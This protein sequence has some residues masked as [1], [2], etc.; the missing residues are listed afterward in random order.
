MIAYLIA[1][2]CV[3]LAGL[4]IGVYALVQHNQDRSK[5]N[6]LVDWLEA[7][8]AEEAKTLWCTPDELPQLLEQLSADHFSETTETAAGVSEYMLPSVRLH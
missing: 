6:Q 2:S 7:Y 8:Q 3:C 4:A 5:L 1:L